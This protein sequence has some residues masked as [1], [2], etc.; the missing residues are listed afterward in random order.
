MSRDLSH[1]RPLP[2]Q[3]PT[4][5]H[6]YI[7]VIT[8]SPTCPNVPMKWPFIFQSRAVPSSDALISN[9]QNSWPA[10]F[11][12]TTTPVCALQ[13]CTATGC[14]ELA[15]IPSKK[16]KLEYRTPTQV[17][18]DIDR[19]ITYLTVIYAVVLYVPHSHK[20]WTISCYEVLV[21][22]VCRQ[23]LDGLVFIL[24]C[25]QWSWYNSNRQNN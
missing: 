24:S 9:G 4:N 21:V 7:H 10:Y 22:W 13:P 8:K 14:L 18:V 23:S 15:F 11:T 3:I 25:T 17:H 6:D 12:S 1:S 16:R 19:N 2:W 5:H 20:T